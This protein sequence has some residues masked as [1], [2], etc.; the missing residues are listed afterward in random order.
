MSYRGIPCLKSP[1]DLS[2]Y[3][4]LI[5]RLLPGT[6]VEVGTKY[7]G[8]ALWFADMLNAHGVDQVHVIS[9]DIEPL[10]SFCDPQIT[11]M[12][13]NA[14]ALQE[15]LD[16]ARIDDLLRPIL[17][18]EDSSHRYEDSLAVLDFFH[19]HLASGDYIIVEDG[20]LSQ[21]SDPVYERFEDGPNR[22]VSAFL[23]KRPHEYEIDESLRDLLGYNV[24]YNPNGW[25][26]RV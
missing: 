9:I 1:F 15:V 3:M 8:G 22:A 12:D 6:V 23:S 20:N 26:R 18:V 21:F 24:T 11:F 17:V 14:R 19:E 25:L 13:G 4:M 5:Q 7:G 16:T 10:A 2:L